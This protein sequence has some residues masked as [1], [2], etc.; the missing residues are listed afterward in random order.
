V[1]TEEIGSVHSSAHLHLV[2]LN[3]SLHN[4]PA[5]I[6]ITGRRAESSRRETSDPVGLVE[7]LDNF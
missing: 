7:T 6:A 5:T 2:I 1:Q 3:A 4:T